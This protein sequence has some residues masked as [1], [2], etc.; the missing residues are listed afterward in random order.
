MDL[1]FDGH[2]RDLEAV[3]AAAGVTRFPL[4][5][6][7]QG[8]AIAIAYAVR[9]P[10]RVSHLVLYGA[11]ARGRLARATSQRERDEAELMYQMVELGWGK[12]NPAFRQVFAMQFLPEGTPDQHRW[13]ND[14]QRLS[15]SPS[16]AARLLRVFGNVDICELAPKV[17]CPTLILH[18]RDD[19]RIPFDQA[20]QLAALIPGSRFVPL[21][22]RNHIL[23]ADEPAW[24]EFVATLR[25]F[26]PQPTPAGERDSPPSALAPLSPRERQVLE[27]IATGLENDA[28]AKRLSLSEKTVRNHITSIFDKLDVHRRAQAI[29][30]A[31]DA[32]L[33]YWRR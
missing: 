14:L 19:E 16:I 4:F 25:G 32:G 2:V 22:S 10:E 15:S 13:F 29:V 21:A 18:A 26:L 9:H 24:N 23:L 5:G 12:D 7:S 6:S 20:R 17:T 11:Y 1:S 8:G 33:G 30:R 31:R 3:V 27:L 28:I